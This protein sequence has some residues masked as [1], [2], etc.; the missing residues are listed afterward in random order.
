MINKIKI[1]KIVFI[2]LLSL[3]SLVAQTVNFTPA[4]QGTD[5]M[6]YN[7]STST[8]ANSGGLTGGFTMTGTAFNDFNMYILQFSFDGTSWNTDVSAMVATTGGL[9]AGGNGGRFTSTDGN[10]QISVSHEVLAAV[11]TWPGN[12]GS[13]RLSIKHNLNS[14]WPT[15]AVNGKQLFMTDQILLRRQRS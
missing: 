11:S 7:V 9:V 1:L 10:A 6:R 15:I 3:K 12:D 14:S 13:I 2:A 4:G 5:Y 8:A